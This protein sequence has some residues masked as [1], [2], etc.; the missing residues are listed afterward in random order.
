MLGFI[1]SMDMLGHVPGTNFD[2]TFN[3]LLLAAA[4]LYLRHFKTKNQAEL[5]RLKKRIEYR[6]GVIY[7]RYKRKLRSY[8]RN[9]QYRAGVAKRHYQRLAMRYLRRHYRAVKHFLVMDYRRAKRETKKS[10]KETWLGILGLTYYPV[11]RLKRRVQRVVR[12]KYRAT[13]HFFVMDWRRTKRLTKRSF[14]NAYRA[15][16]L[17]IYRRRRRITRAVQK[18]SRRTSA[19]LA[20][21][22]LV[23]TLIFIK[24]VVTQGA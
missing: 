4:V 22:K 11:R 23:K 14:R 2:I 16:A 7:R 9:K 3:E 17:A 8:L 13:V 10:F 5:L 6:S 21:T 20:Q 19:W 1:L 24:N 15:A 12:R 18:I